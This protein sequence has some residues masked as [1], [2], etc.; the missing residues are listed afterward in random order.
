MLNK[1]IQQLRKSKGLSQE[2]LAIKLNVVR[3]TISKW[4]NGLSVPDSDMLIAIASEFDT[5]VSVLLGETIS[6]NEENDIEVI[7][8]KLEDIN[9]QLAKRKVQ[10]IKTIRYLFVSLCII[11]IL[12]FIGL[13]LFQSDYLNWNYNNPE[14]AV[15]GTL[16]HGLEFTFVRV[17][18]IILVLLI[19]GIIC[20]FVKK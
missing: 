17:A 3:Q 5:T 14:L 2:E 1:N 16:L 20:T 18:P 12:V 19:I 6:D 13:C 4:E 8:K 10:K 7:S 11:I 9:L 15:V